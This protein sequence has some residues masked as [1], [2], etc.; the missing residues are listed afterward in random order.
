MAEK[1]YTPTEIDNINLGR[2]AVIGATYKDTRGYE[3]LG[4][5]GN[6]LKQKSI[7]KETTF[8]PSDTRPETNVQDAIDG[9]NKLLGQVLSATLTFTFLSEDD[10]VVNTILNSVLTSANFKSITIIPIETDDTSLDDFKLNGLVFNIENIV[11]STSFDIRA[12][13][14][15]GAT[16]PYT[17]TYKIIYS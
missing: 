3:F 6:V 13:A 9:M 5:E 16:G 1:I 17:I 8:I 15:N 2:K 14:L 11:D 10:S 12:T 4:I 7:A